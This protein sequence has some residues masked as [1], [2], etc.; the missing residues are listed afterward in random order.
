MARHTEDQLKSLNA[1]IRD[2]VVG[3]TEHEEV[4]ESEQLDELS[5]ATKAS[6]RQK[7]A[8]NITKRA[9]AAAA[10]KKKGPAPK[11]GSAERTGGKVDPKVKKRAQGIGRAGGSE[12]YA[13]DAAT[14]AAHTA[15]KLKRPMPSD[16]HAADDR[17]HENQ[18]SKINMK[19]KRNIAAHGPAHA[20]YDKK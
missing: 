7:A 10:G 2:I 17:D 14:Q 4:V 9:F 3:K 15:R 1:T 18:I 12:K 13:R 19:R 6:Y 5:P 16:D 20:P 8:K 11:F